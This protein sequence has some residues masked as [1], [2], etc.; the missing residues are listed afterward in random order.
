MNKKFIAFDVGSCL[1]ESLDRFKNYDEIYAFEPSP[2][3]FKRLTTKFSDQKHIKFFQVAISNT[4]EFLPFNFHDAYGYSSLLDIDYKGEFTK[5][6][7][8]LDPGFDR[9]IETINVETQRLDT[10]MDKHDISHIDFLKIDTQGNDL[11]V[12][13]S[14]GSKI[15]NV[16]IIELEVHLKKMYKNA[17]TKTDALEYMEQH[18]FDL[19]KTD[20]NSEDLKEYEENLTFKNRNFME[21]EQEKYIWSNRPDDEEG[22]IITNWFSI[23]KYDKRCW[24][25][26][27]FYSNP[28]DVRSFALEQK[29]FPGEGAVGHR[30]KK[31]FFFEGMKESFQEIM[32]KKIK[33]NGEH[34]WYYPGVNGRFQYCPAGTNTVYHCDEQ[35]YAALVYLTPNAPPQCGTTFFRHRETSRRHNR[36]IDWEDGE[37]YKVFPGNTFLDKTPYETVDVIGNVYNR[38]VIFDGGLIHSASEYFGHDINTCRLHHTFFFNCEE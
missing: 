8:E 5:K 25:V 23:N 16:N 14:L 34:G 37:G 28:D 6:N 10:F 17:A 31:Q 33:E 27:N 32:G 20:C 36:D 3:S 13:K 4:S 21:Q 24:I 26:D 38:L 1:G 12:I 11:N 15:K 18:N 30:T 7:I 35:Q 9:I 2:W 29:Y 22:E 19:I